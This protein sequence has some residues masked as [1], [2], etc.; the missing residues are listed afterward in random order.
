MGKIREA[1]V[2]SHESYNAE[3]YKLQAVFLLQTVWVQLQLF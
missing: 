2:C 3:K 1:H